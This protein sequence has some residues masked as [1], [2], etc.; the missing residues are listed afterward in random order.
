MSLRWRLPHLSDQTIRFLAQ[1][2]ERLYLRG[3]SFEDAMDRVCLPLRMGRKSHP[4][5]H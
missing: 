2:V 3:W 4:H 5:A 1:R